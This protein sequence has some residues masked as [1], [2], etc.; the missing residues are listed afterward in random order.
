M[1]LEQQTTYIINVPIEVDS[2]AIDNILWGAVNQGS[3]YLLNSVEATR[4]DSNGTNAED[5]TPAIFGQIQIGGELTFEALE[6]D[7][8]TTFEKYTLTLE[9]FLNTL[10]EYTLFKEQVYG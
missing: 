7:T 5:G 10:S 3:P 8:D 2:E 6:D 4:E 1:R 9:D